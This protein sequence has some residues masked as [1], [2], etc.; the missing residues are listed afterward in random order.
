LARLTQKLRLK[1][2]HHFLDSDRFLIKF[3]KY[4]YHYSR[5]LCALIIRKWR[6][7]G[8]RRDRAYEE[9]QPMISQFRFDLKTRELVMTT[10][11]RRVT[12][13]WLWGGAKATLTPIHNHLKN[14]S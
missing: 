11:Y 10:T 14:N 1:I 12:A 2:K 5:Q 7:G 3:C 13:G 8:Y 9:A 4:C 6:L